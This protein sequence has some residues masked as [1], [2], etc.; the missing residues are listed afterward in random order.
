MLV[1]ASNP[2]PYKI[3]KKACRY[4]ATDLSHH[5][6]QLNDPLLD[7]INL[8]LDVLQP[9]AKT[10]RN[11]AGPQ[12]SKIHKHVIITRKHQNTQL[13]DS[14]AA[15]NTKITAQIL[16]KLTTTTPS[17][18]HLLYKLHDHNYLNTHAHNKILRVAR[19][20]TNLTDSNQVHPKHIS[21]TTDLHLDDLHLKTAA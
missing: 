2:C 20:I 3:K 16:H 21:T 12:S 15:C 17:T 11:Q 7:R 13:A 9:T 19:T 5:N 10:L 8:S 6:R 18:L 1:T 4:T 14:N